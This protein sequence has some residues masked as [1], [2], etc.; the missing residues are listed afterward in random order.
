MTLPVINSHNS[1]SQLEEV[2]LGDVYPSGWYDHLKPEIRDVFQQITEI[3]KQDLLVIEN[4]LTELGIIVRRPQYHHI[5][6]FVGANGMLKKP[7][8]CP[9]DTHI[10]LGNSLLVPDQV[11][12]AWYH[13]IAEYLKHG[14]HVILGGANNIINGA[15]VVRL[16]RDVIIDKGMP[17]ADLSYVN[18]NPFKDYRITWE[19]NGGHIDACFAVLKPGLIIANDYYDGYDRN[20]P[21]WEKIILKEP[22]YWQHIKLPP[23]KFVNNGRFW[24][25]DVS[26]NQMFND[27]VI[28]YAQ[29]WIGNYTETYFELNC[30]VINESNVM[31]LGYNAA[32]E[33]TL[34]SHGITVHWVPFRARSFWDGG[35]HCLTVDIRRQS[36][37]RDYF[38]QRG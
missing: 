38:P 19:E 5:D 28:K 27:H 30:L 21:G 8:I 15:S 1:W 26:I 33:R 36:N 2:W 13:V 6:N 34:N 37:I 4:K 20:F 11:N 32:L 18:L 12:F 23:Q 22:T 3:T 35:M 10:T 17:D 29:D 14:Q 9:R 24:I 16:G 7:E 25:E 31:M